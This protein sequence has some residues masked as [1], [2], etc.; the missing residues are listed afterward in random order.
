MASPLITTRDALVSQPSIFCTV[1]G[2]TNIPDGTQ[3]AINVQNQQGNVALSC[4]YAPAAIKDYFFDGPVFALYASEND[5]DYNGIVISGGLENGAAAP[6]QPTW[7]AVQNG[8]SI[9]INGQTES[10][11]QGV[12]FAMAA[13]MASN[14]VQQIL[15]DTNVQFLGQMVSR[16]Q[17]YIT[18]WL[19]GLVLTPY[20]PPVAP[21]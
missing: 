19:S 12:D 16:V 17:T 1:S 2:W 11:F 6:G 8:A 13:I 3:I 9:T 14:T 4:F 21:T 20:T 18:S 7:S 5:V 10:G 15:Q